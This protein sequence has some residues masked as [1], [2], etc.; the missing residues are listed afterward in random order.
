MLCY[1]SIILSSLVFF[2]QPSLSHYRNSVSENCQSPT[3]PHSQ[4]SYSPAQSPGLPPSTW[5]NF[6]DNYH[7]Q[8]QQQTQALQHQFEQFKMV[9]SLHFRLVSIHFPYWKIKMGS[10]RC[11]LNIAN[12]FE[13]PET[14]VHILCLYKTMI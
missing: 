1:N 13:R 6:T 10:N 11:I 5:N 7:L 9:G 8:Q 12:Q 4:P 2:F 14:S 3:S